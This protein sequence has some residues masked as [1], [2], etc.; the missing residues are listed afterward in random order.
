MGGKVL[1][2]VLLASQSLYEYELSGPYIFQQLNLYEGLASLY[3]CC[4]F[5]SSFDQEEECRAQPDYIAAFDLPLEDLIKRMNAGS[6]FYISALPSQFVWKW[7]GFIKRR[8]TGL[9]SLYCCCLFASS[10]D[11]EEE[12]GAQ[13]DYIAAFDLSSS[14]DFESASEQ[15]L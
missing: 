11:Q 15:L 6:A 1:Q 3:C 14:D 5:A 12:C 7:K 13:P 2:L 9:A 10:F 4:L 8:N